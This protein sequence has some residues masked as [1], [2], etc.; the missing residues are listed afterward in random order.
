MAGRMVDW[1]VLRKAETKAGLMD[2][3]MVA[4]K[5]AKMATMTADKRE[6]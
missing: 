3:K 1:M 4:M 5:V 6:V 2:E